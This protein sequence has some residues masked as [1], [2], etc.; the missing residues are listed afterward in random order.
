[1]C[2]NGRA[3]IWSAPKSTRW[4]Y[5]SNTGQR[6]IMN[7]TGGLLSRDDDEAPPTMKQLDQIPAFIIYGPQGL[8][9]N[10]PISAIVTDPQQL[11]ATESHWEWGDYNLLSN[12]VLEAVPGDP[13]FARYEPAR[14]VGRRVYFDVKTGNAIRA[15][16]VRGHS[17]RW[18]GSSCYSGHNQ[19][20]HACSGRCALATTAHSAPVAVLLGGWGILVALTSRRSFRRPSPAHASRCQQGQHAAGRIL[21]GAARRYG[22]STR[23]D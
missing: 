2:Q 15:E 1:V 5:V 23:S 6:L 12:D 16:D 8:I 13:E 17:I 10:I 22:R 3:H 9:R 7:P 11:V 19:P 4:G 20:L 14:V 21:P 18:A